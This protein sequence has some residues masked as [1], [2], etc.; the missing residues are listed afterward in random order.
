MAVRLG[1]NSQRKKLTFEWLSVTSLN[2]NLD[3]DVFVTFDNVQSGS[4]LEVHE[5]S[6]DKFYVVFRDNT[7]KYFD[8]PRYVTYVDEVEDLCRI[9]GFECGDAPNNDNLRAENSGF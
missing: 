5:E 4:R 7:Y 6:R 3:N 8:A 1:A 2:F 9:L